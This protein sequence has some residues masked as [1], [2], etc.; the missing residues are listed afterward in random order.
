MTFMEATK[1]V[2]ILRAMLLS[3]ETPEV[4]M[5]PTAE[6]FEE[7]RANSGIVFQQAPAHIQDSGSASGIEAD[8]IDSL[9]PKKSRIE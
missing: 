6:D 7:V 1:A 9:E 4:E 8:K 2:R 3:I 5:E